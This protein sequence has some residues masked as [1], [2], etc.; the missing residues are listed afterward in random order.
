MDLW[1]LPSSAQV[2]ALN[3]DGFS[4][5]CARGQVLERI[6]PGLD[7]ALCQAFGWTRN[8]PW[9]AL[10]SP[11]SGDEHG[12]WLMADLIN[13]RAEV[14][15]VRVMALAID[16]AAG[17]PGLAALFDALRPWLAEE[18]I[19]IVA[20]YGG[21][22]LLRCPSRHGAP[23]AAAPDA[24]LG[25]DLRALLPGDLRWQRRINELQVV[26][27]QQ[28]SNE[29]RLARQLPSW[30]TLWFW[31][32]GSADQCPPL[33]LTRLAS[34]DPL[35]MALAGHHQAESIAFTAPSKLPVLRDLRDPRLLQQSWQAG[36]RPREAIL[37]CVDGH[38]WQ[39][40]PWRFWRFWR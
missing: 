32:H 17:D 23:S 14:A 40:Q 24:L 29:A 33:P 35:L 26:L 19:E 18:S 34:N 16:S 12:L 31:G 8:P 28:S 9:A 13:V 27:A 20:T 25:R 1:L 36:L 3:L 15:G 10:L 7:P 30:N 2:E 21:R 5:L 39:L 11:T 4:A 6:A 37:R 38:G 22:A